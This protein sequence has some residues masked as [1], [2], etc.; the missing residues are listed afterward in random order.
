MTGQKALSSD[1]NNQEFADETAQRIAVAAADLFISHGFENTSTADIARASSTTK[2]EIYD[3]FA[4]K[5]E[6]LE[7]V[8]KLVY[9]PVSE[10]RMYNGEN[11]EDTLAKIGTETVQQL[12]NQTTRKL[13]R[14]AFGAA[15]QY[16]NAPKIFWKEG[17]GRQID[18]LAFI[19][20]QCADIDISSTRTA[21]AA[22][23]QFIIDCCGSFVLT[24]MIDNSY[25]P[26][27]AEIKSHV[28]KAS[29]NLMDRFAI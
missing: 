29:Q 24:I 19:L 5:D 27:A 26:T 20:H 17:P 25:A 13:L 8:M 16:P 11:L 21:Q 14:S 3:R 7:Q 1:Q 28:E 4:S 12:L 18:S 9:N 23:K 2:R 15:R 10:L 6:L 22:A